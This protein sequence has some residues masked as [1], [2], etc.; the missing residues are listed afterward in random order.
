MPGMEPSVA[1]MVERIYGAVA[2]SS[3][4]LCWWMDTKFELTGQ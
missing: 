2:G 3:L 4:T 1:A